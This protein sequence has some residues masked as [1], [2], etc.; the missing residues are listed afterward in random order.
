M[1]PMVPMRATLRRA[2]G[3]LAFAVLPIASSCGART[4]LASVAPSQDAGPPTCA[5]RLASAPPGSVVW[6]F[7][8]ATPAAGPVAADPSGATYFIAVEALTGAQGFTYTVLSVDACGALRWQSEPV[9][10][11]TTSGTRPVAMVTGDQLVVQTV[12]VDAFDLATG[13]RRWSTDLAAFGAAAGLGNVFT[14]TGGPVG[15]AAAFADGSMLVNFGDAKAL[16]R[17][18]RRGAVSV[19]SRGASAFPG[20]AVSLAIDAAGHVD[21]LVNSTLRGTLVVSFDA[22]GAVRFAASLDCTRSFIGELVSGRSFVAQ[23]NGLCALGFDGASRFNNRAQTGG[24]LVVD[25]ADNL[26]FTVNQGFASAD[27]S[28]RSR[29]ARSLDS[30]MFPSV[31][32]GSRDVFALVQPNDDAPRMGIIALDRSTGATTWS[33]TLREHRLE[34]VLRLNPFPVGRM[35]LVA[36]G[37]LVLGGASM[38]LGVGTGRQLVD[39]LAPWPAP[40]GGVDQRAAATGR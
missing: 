10:S 38:A 19:F 4:E 25:A 8:F 40:R 34:T 2:L 33:T 39:P 11:V 15:P 14:Q 20:V 37:V 26:Y 24:A 17:V 5:Q 31:A 27:V 6:T 1:R 32:L 30:A 22:S 28:G 9:R 7:P 21:M 35:L 36:P 13:A 16:L 23:Q 3:A 29:W 12:S 18:D